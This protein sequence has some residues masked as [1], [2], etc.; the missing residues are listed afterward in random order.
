MSDHDYTRQYWGHA[1][2]QLE[3]NEY[4]GHG[5]GIAVGDHVLCKMASGRVGRMKVLK[6]KYMTNVHDQ[7]FA[8]LMLD[9]YEPGSP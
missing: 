7:W 2:E 1:F 6:I 3:G 8:T 9:G 5:L 4:A